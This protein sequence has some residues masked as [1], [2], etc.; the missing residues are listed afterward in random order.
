PILRTPV[1]WL[2][3]FTP[4]EC[5]QDHQR[6]QTSL[7]LA[8]SRRLMIHSSVFLFYPRCR[9]TD[10]TIALLLT[11]STIESNEV[12]QRTVMNSIDRKYQHHCQ[13]LLCNDSATLLL[14]NQRAP[15]IHCSTDRAVGHGDQSH[16]T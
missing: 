15:P 13:T 11:L 8:S 3:R 1:G 10:I 6:G 2:S 4:L 7:E 5:P 16:Y 14:K 9:P 12:F